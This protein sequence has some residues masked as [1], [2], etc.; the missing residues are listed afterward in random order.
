MLIAHPGSTQPLFEMVGAVAALGYATKLWTGYFFD[1]GRPLERLAASLPERLRAR[2]LREMRRRSS[3]VVPAAAVAR[4]AWLE[5]ATIAA[6]RLLPHGLISDPQLFGLRNAIFDRRVAA[7]ARSNR[8]AVAI[9]VDS[10]ALLTIRACA[11]S[12]VRSVLH[13][14]IG[15]VSVG[16]PLLEEEARLQP[17]WADSLPVGMP[18]HLIERA[19][20]EALEAELVLSSS[21]YVTSTLLRI[22]VASERIRCPSGVRIDRFKPPPA[23]RAEAGVLRILFVGQISQRKG[24]AYLLEAVRRLG[25]R[26][27]EVMLVG[28]VIGRGRGLEPYRDLLRLEA[29]RPHSELP[30]LYRSADLF[31]YPSLHEGSAQAVMEAMASGLP[32]I[33]TPNAG[34]LVR[35][36][37]EGLVVPIRDPDALAGAIASLLDDRA[38]LRAMGAAARRRVEQHSWL[39]Y[40]EGL[41][42]ILG[43][44]IHG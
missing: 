33:V 32:A 10:A 13:Q 1:Q 6:A 21:D 35:D 7:W 26:N 15:H 42:R 39:T 37:V 3:D 20:Q 4:M 12:G 34:S 44:L 9:L 14:S 18:A 16:Q 38:R 36:G 19:R 27:I 28:S 29:N 23:P 2:V 31:V 24:I 17:A 25:R 41:G 40:R 30:E 22:G 8:P 5:L 11:Q 43:E